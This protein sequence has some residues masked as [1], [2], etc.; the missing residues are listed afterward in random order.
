MS[1]YSATVWERKPARETLD[2]TVNTALLQSF[3][4][5]L[6]SAQQTRTLMLGGEG[7]QVILKCN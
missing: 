7:A 2:A 4:Q 6:Y 5:R 3:V 1:L